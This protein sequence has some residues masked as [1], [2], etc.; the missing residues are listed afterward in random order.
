[1]CSKVPKFKIPSTSRCTLNKIISNLSH[2][3]VSRNFQAK[4]KQYAKEKK[5]CDFMI[6]IQ[7][8]ANTA[9]LELNTKEAIVSMKII[10]AKRANNIHAKRCLIHLIDRCLNSAWFCIVCIYLIRINSFS[11][12]CCTA[13]AGVI[14]IDYSYLD[15][16]IRHV[17]HT[18]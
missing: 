12:E 5:K 10:F 9:A 13:T 8:G 3:P 11:V 14:V 15:A 7:Y 2:A 1:M 18:S 6:I 4:T 16:F 17:F